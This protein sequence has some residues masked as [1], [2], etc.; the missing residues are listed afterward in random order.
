MKSYFKPA[1]LRALVMSFFSESLIGTTGG[2]IR[3]ELKIPL[4]R[5]AS[6]RRAWASPEGWPI[7]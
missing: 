1:A 4:W 2:S 6:L 3:A 5:R 7:W